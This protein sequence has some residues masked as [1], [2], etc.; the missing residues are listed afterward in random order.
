[1]I[2]QINSPFKA[3]RLSVA[4]SLCALL[5]GCGGGSSGDDASSNAGRARAQALA[6]AAAPTII[7]D[8]PV[9]YTPSRNMGLV[10]L[11][12]GHEQKVRFEN[13]KQI[14]V[15]RNDPFQILVP[16]SQFFDVLISAS[17]NSNYVA[18]GSIYIGGNVMAK[19]YGES[20]A[21]WNMAI[22][23]RYTF[24][25]WSYGSLVSSG[26][27]RVL[28]IKAITDRYSSTKTSKTEVD[29]LVYLSI[30]YGTPNKPSTREY[31]MVT[32]RLKPSSTQ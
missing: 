27:Y 14:V 26:S 25:G 17:E 3:A 21:G 6:G 23:D 28:N 29:L 4:A 15:V 20:S 11:Q 10:F 7:I 16:N 30:P 13:G 9:A 2:M 12:D 18:G 1:M 8:M 31:D 24:N 32:L 22:S 5:I 19:G